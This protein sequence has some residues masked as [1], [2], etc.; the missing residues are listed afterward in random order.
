[1]Q[2][3]VYGA[4]WCGPCKMVKGTLSR[5]NIDYELIDVDAEPNKAADANVRGLPTIIITDGDKEVRRF[6]GSSADLVEKIQG[7][8]N[9]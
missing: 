6:V 9:E 4:D 1:M 7:A 3:V 8:M 2:V 5:A